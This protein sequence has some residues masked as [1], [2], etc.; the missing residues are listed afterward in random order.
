VITSPQVR[1]PVTFVGGLSFYHVK[2]ENIY[3]VAVSNSNT[4]AMSAFEICAKVASLG[5]A[6]FGRFNEDAVKC[7]F[8]LIYELLDGT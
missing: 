5:E 2:H 1:S 4:N 7:N 8:S 6:Y 3:L